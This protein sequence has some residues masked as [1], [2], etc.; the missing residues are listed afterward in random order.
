MVLVKACKEILNVLPD[1]ISAVVIIV[2]CCTYHKL[3]S[4]EAAAYLIINR[5]TAYSIRHGAYGKVTL[6]M[7]VMVVDILSP[8]RSMEA[9]V[10]FLPAFF[11]W[12]HES[13]L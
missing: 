3:I 11:L 9:T 13:C 1:N 10:K 5:D 6:V 2:R 4:A 8:S 7:A 12:S